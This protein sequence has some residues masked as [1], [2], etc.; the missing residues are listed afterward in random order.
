MTTNKQ[1]F[2]KM[3][4]DFEKK[5]EDFFIKKLPGLPKNIKE[6]IVKYG[7]YLAV[8]LLVLS[9]PVILG[10]FGLFIVTTPFAL[11]GG[12]KGFNYVISIVFGLAI[13]ILQIMAIS[14]L[15]KRQMRAWKLLFYISL[16]EAISN[17]LE[18]DLAGLIVGT[19]LSWYILFQIKS[20]YK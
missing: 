10:L 17:L 11:M 13:L 14:G 8:V 9:I 7:P 3:M 4:M 1:T 2:K 18:L 15:F 6:I 20:F 12:S 16:I 5:L 19:G